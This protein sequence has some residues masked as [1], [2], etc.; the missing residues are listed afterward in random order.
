MSFSPRVLVI[1]P[2]SAVA[3][4]LGH[5]LH[6]AGFEVLGPARSL[7]EGLTLVEGAHAAI[8]EAVLPDARLGD[9]ARA[10]RRASHR[11]LLV[12]ALSVELT[13]ALLLE[14][15][16][17][18]ALALPKGDLGAVVEALFRSALPA[19]PGGLSPTGRAEDAG[20]SES[21]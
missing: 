5:G 8:I 4:A 7:A 3:G 6:T 2:H 10:L 13:D 18:G 21:R 12:I 17:C 11:G 9:A 14:A 19:E 15:G 20:A 1:E 16:D